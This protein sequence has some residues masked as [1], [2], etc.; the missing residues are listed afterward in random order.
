MLS[1]QIFFIIPGKSKVISARGFRGSSC[2]KTNSF[3]RKKKLK[4]KKKKRKKKKKKKKKKKL[5][6]KKN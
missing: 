4:K 3:C 1:I 2:L 6:K 5:K